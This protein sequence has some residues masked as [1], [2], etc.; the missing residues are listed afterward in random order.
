MR[1]LSSVRLP[2]I[3]GLWRIGVDGEERITAVHPLPP[4]SSSAGEDWNCDWLSPM[5]VDLQINGGLGLAFP[6]LSSSDLP[7][8]LELL[9][10]L[11]RD[12][13]EAIAPTLVTCGV[14]ELR[15]A[16]GVLREARALHQPG[17]C[18]LLGA[19]LEGPFL[20]EARRGAHPRQHLAAPSLE[21]LNSR[22]GGFEQEISLVTLAP[23]L[24]GA[25]AVI[26][27]LLQ[28]GIQ[29]SLGHSE[30]NE[31]QA[32]AAFESGVGMITH[33]FNAMAGLHHRAPGPIAAAAL[34]GDVALGLIAD[35]V[36]VAPSMAVLLQRLMPNQVV[37]VS[38]ALAPYGLADGV[39]RWDERALIVEKGSC[40][41]EDGT[42]AG[43][44][45]PLL[46]AVRRL[47]SWSGKAGQAIAAATLLPRRV[48]GEQRGSQ[49]LL[50][51]RPLAHCLRW[52][53]PAQDLRW[54]RA[55]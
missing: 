9:E 48:L 15:Q 11:W 16:L 50:L 46:E 2:A 30:A 41:L 24:D 42:L 25:D 33:A 22:I 27:A 3:D 35:G 51:G 6:E 38:D 14:A 54:Q 45:L 40:R 44:T 23:E 39:H 21:A 20:A 1:W 36:H 7:N 5:G 8:L 47:A 49:E 17:R 55:A 34:R 32:S 13:V 19:H 52:S 28:L 12:G 10:L 18:Q 53:G 4:G 31:A 37:L 43:V 29:V 26:E